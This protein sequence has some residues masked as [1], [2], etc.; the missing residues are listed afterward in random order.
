MLSLSFFW[1]DTEFLSALAQTINRIRSLYYENGG[2]SL[3][4]IFLTIEG[5]RTYKVLQKYDFNINKKSYEMSYDVESREVSILIP[6]TIVGK[7]GE[8]QIEYL[9]NLKQLGELL[10]SDFDYIKGCDKFTNAPL[11][12]SED[13]LEYNTMYVYGSMTLKSLEIQNIKYEPQVSNS[14]FFDCLFKAIN[15]EENYTLDD[16]VYFR[17][18]ISENI[19]NTNPFD[20]EG[21]SFYESS[22]NGIL[23]RA[24]KSPEDA[25]G[26]IYS[27][28][29][30]PP[31]Y[32]TWVPDM[33]G[34]NLRI[35]DVV[36][37]R[38]SNQE[39]PP[40]EDYINMLYDGHY[41]LV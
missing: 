41:K 40:I 20:E 24:S 5:D 37:T 4:I 32:I 15:P 16:V 27:D 13:E 11:F 14:T 6:E 21:R 25:Q 12:L 22:D 26:W 38:K 31:E 1:K 34:Y 30:L 28:T 23:Q 9:V 2:E 17:K 7:E 19:T 36:Y 35:N 18:T 39:H 33:I 10:N 3:K 29:E 8:R